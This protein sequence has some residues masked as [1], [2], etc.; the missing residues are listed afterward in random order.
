MSRT[1]SGVSEKTA[2]T[3]IFDPGS[4]FA[5]TGLASVD[6]KT[7]AATVGNMLD[8][9]GAKAFQ[10]SVVEVI[11]GTTPAAGSATV[12]M[13]LFEGST[14]LSSWITLGTLAFGDAAGTFQKSVGFGNFTAVAEGANWT[15]GASINALRG[16]VQAKLRVNV[17][18][19]FTNATTATVSVYLH[20]IA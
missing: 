4:T 13:A 3:R 20:V 18:T 16:G 10:L 9:G 19:A 1:S 5:G 14:Q 2:V 6:L 17:A 8:I 11:A 15:V 12:D 7:Q